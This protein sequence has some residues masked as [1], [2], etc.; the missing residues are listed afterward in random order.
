MFTV[1]LLASEKEGGEVGDF[2]ELAGEADV[3]AMAAVARACPPITSD[4]SLEFPSGGRQT[5]VLVFVFSWNGKKKRK[6]IK[7]RLT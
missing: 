4:L 2:Q 7:H 3:A 5:S 6:H 1:R